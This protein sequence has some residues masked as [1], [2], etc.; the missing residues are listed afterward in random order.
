[1]MRKKGGHF[2]Y[3]HIDVPR[4]YDWRPENNTAD[5]LGPQWDE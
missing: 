1:V 3:T 5:L 4:K 2:E